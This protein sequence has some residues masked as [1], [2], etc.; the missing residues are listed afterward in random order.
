MRGVT[1][2]GGLMLVCGMAGV[3]GGAE[4]AC[5]T[6]P[7]PCPKF[8]CRTLHAVWDAYLREL[9]AQAY[10]EVGMTTTTNHYYQDI[11]TT[12]STEM[13]PYTLDGEKEVR[14]YPKCVPLCGKSANSKG[15]QAWQSPQEVAPLG[16]A[17][18]P[19]DA[20]GP[21]GYCTPAPKGKGKTVDS[22]LNP[23]DDEYAPPQ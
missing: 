8:E 7:D 5:A 11:F 21:R 9:W 4:R 14:L 6:D 2:L 1:L 23:N 3:F 15:K 18:T 19:K 10:F 20:V 22:L 16:E 13:N 12:S 17:W